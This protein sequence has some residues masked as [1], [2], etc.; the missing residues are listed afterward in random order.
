MLNNTQN[1]SIFEYLIPLITNIEFYFSIIMN[2]IGISLNLMCVYIFNKDSL[3]KKTNLGFLY[4][5]LCLL[6]ILALLNSTIIAC[7]SYFDSDPYAHSLFSCK[8]LN[9][10]NVFVFYCPS[11][12][13]IIIGIEVFRLVY[14]PYSKKFS[15]KRYIFLALFMLLFCFIVTGVLTFNFELQ[16]EETEED[17][18]LIYDNLLNASNFSNNTISSYV[19]TTTRIIDLLFDATNIFFKVLLPFMII[20]TLNLFI[21]RKLLNS[22][23]A[24]KRAKKSSIRRNQFVVSSIIINFIFIIIYLPWTASFFVYHKFHFEKNLDTKGILLYIELVKAIFGCI[25]YINNFS[26]LFI[27][28][29]FNYLFYSEFITLCRNL[30]LLKT[31]EKNKVSASYSIDKE[32]NSSSKL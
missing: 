10:W 27:N 6:N 18:T 9:L 2:P 5:V 29:K 31:S 19:C 4:M 15:K 17:Y 26:P 12:Q 3:N 16:L 1:E 24:L 30:G 25:T 32:M 23:K 20:L 21:T 14:F 13:Q 8:L 7:L 22:A 28:L 11:I